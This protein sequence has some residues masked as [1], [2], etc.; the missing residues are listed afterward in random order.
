[1]GRHLGWLVP[2]LLATGCPS[3]LEVRPTP[4]HRAD[5]IVVLGNR[6]PVDADGRV[7]AETRRRVE[8]GV[9]LHREGVAPRLL[10]TGGR[11]P[12]GHV[13]A[14][15][16]RDL[17]ISLGVPSE[18]ILIEPLA[19]DTID[20]A[21]H[22]IALLCGPDP[23]CIPEVVV[24]SSPYHLQRAQGLFECAGARVQ[25]APTDV[26]DDPTY[27]RNFAWSERFVRL[28]YG[29]INECERVRRARDRMA[30]DRDGVEDRR[31]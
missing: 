5:V 16:M 22:A 14:E 3:A 28:Y 1:M 26:P 21:G 8:K 7:R 20:N 23:T 19:R 9:S 4:L 6:P 15:V 17:A 13:E 18:A 2:C 25:L 29:F 30:A 31:P 12:S 24:V 10:M 27:A 11:A